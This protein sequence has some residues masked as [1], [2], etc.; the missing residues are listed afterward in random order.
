MLKELLFLLML[1]SCLLALAEDQ[2]Q[3]INALWDFNDP[4]ATE[5]RFRQFFDSQDDISLRAEILSQIARAQGLQMKIEEA[6]RSLDLADSLLAA[7]D[8]SA[9]GFKIAA[10]RLMLERGRVFNTNGEKEKAKDF[11]LKAYDYGRDHK[12]DRY[13]VDA[14][15]MMGIVE[16]PEKQMDW[17][18]RAIDIIENSEDSSLAGWLGIMYNNS[19]WTYHD[20]GKY[21]EALELFE[22]DLKWRALV[23]DSEGERI[24]KWSVARTYRSLHRYDEA[25]AIQKELERYLIDNELPPDGY[26]LEE[27]GELYLIKNNPEEAKKYFAQAFDILSQDQWIQANEAERLKRLE[28]LSK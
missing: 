11:F 3:D 2:K 23:G 5:E 13:L 14:A 28:E 4:A 6:H 22:K 26:V 16:P 12:I 25:L 20:L 19:A 8:T 17:N 10:I 18:L 9:E 15:H 24:A 1:L 7:S 21:E 27:L